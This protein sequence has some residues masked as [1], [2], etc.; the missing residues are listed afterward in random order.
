MIYFF[1]SKDEHIL[2]VQTQKNFE[3]ET[4]EALTWLFS[5]ARMLDI[6]VIEG[7][8][9]GP[10]REMI[11]PWSTAAVEITKNM[12]IEGITRIEEFFPVSD[13]C[14]SDDMIE[15]DKMLQRIY[16]TLDENIFTI[17]KQP[18][19]IIHIEDFEE[20]NKQEGLALSPEEIQYLKDLSE[21]LGRPLTDS[22]VFGFSQ[23]NSEHCRHKIFNGT[24]IIDGKE[25]EST[26][27]KMI[28]KTSAE[29]PGRIVSAYK[30]NVAFVKGPK[31]DQF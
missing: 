24:F 10:R 3:K 16:H 6:K 18:E 22:E 1:R 8:F 23:V 13:S 4:V 26:L 5:E 14:K 9:I 29:N 17:D 7:T 30:D 15:Y 21:K 28:K 27:F 11:T 31:V 25:M 19:Q 12:K 20:Y 2:A